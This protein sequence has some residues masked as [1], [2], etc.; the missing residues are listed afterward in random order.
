MN[1]RVVLGASALV[2]GILGMSATFLPQEILQYIGAPAAGALPSIIQI[3]GALYLSFA[4]Q[5]WMAKDSLIGGIYNRPVA[6]GNLLHFTMGALALGKT[7][8]AGHAPNAILPFA[9]GYALFAV[10]FAVVFFTSPV[11]PVAAL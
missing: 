8:V 7:A 5:N 10:A 11:R 3:I 1:T 4:M 9:I 2:M 6:M